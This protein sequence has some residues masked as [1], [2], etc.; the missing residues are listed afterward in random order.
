V[1]HLRGVPDDPFTAAANHHAGV[2]ALLQL[3]GRSGLKFH[4][5]AASGD[6]SGPSGLIAAGDVV[7]L[8][9]NAQWK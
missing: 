5:S 3:M 9:V 6:T 8:K 2:D 4:R 7:L 1:F